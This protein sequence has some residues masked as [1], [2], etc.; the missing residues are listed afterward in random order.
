MSKVHR[1]SQLLDAQAPESVHVMG[2]QVKYV[3]EATH[4]R[5]KPPRNAGAEEMVPLERVVG[6]V[7]KEDRKTVK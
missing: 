5:A 4:V 3:R 2:L 7:R 6:Q 1:V